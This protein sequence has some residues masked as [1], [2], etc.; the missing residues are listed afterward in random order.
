MFNAVN[1][2]AYTALFS[3]LSGHPSSS[4]WLCANVRFAPSPAVGLVRSLK[5]EGLWGPKAHKPRAFALHTL[6]TT[7]R[8]QGTPN[9]LSV[10]SLISHFHAETR[11]VLPG[12]ASSRSLHV[13][14]GR[15]MV[16]PE[17]QTKLS[18]R[19]KAC[20]FIKSPKSTPIKQNIE[21]PPTT[22][23]FPRRQSS[24]EP[25][26]KL[27]SRKPSVSLRLSTGKEKRL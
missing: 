16:T 17:A 5:T 8:G 12:F 26:S 19:Q 27:L 21:S 25:K 13:L 4:C 20:R 22:H 11:T 24:H 9:P 14:M 2:F 18:I 15:L 10:T 1:S 3:T 7:L 6:L 23:Q